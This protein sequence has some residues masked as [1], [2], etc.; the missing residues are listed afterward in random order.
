MT[1]T[2][3]QTAKVPRQV[4]RKCSKC[5]K[6]NYADC[7]RCFHCTA[8]LFCADIGFVKVKGGDVVPCPKCN[9]DGMEDLDD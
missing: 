8:C 3:K 2:P 5:K 4:K 7:T 6:F 1:D 9:P